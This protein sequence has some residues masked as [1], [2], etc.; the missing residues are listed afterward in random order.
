MSVPRPSKEVPW[1]D[2]LICI[3]LSQF[4]FQQTLLY[5]PFMLSNYS[6]HTRELLSLMIAHWAG[7]HGPM[8]AGEI[9]SVG[10]N[11]GAAYSATIIMTVRLLSLA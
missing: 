11:V 10:R 1:I 8:G 9:H 6:V 7:Q 4:P 5:I 3:M 2:F